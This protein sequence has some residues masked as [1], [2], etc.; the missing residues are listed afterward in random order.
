MSEQQTIPDAAGGVWSF[1]SRVFDWLVTTEVPLA[2][3]IVLLLLSVIREGL[4][5]YFKRG[6]Q[7]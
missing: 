2:V 7:P 4:G 6:Q 5:M 3:V 1:A